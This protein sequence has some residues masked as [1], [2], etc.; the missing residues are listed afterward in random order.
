MR[1]E[2]GVV[3][4]QAGEKE[5]GGVVEGGEHMPGEVA[6]ITNDEVPGV[7]QRKDVGGSG[8]V[9]AVKTGHGEVLEAEGAQGEHALELEQGEGSVLLLVATAGKESGEGI[10]KG[11]GGAVVEEHLRK[12]GEEAVAEA[13]VEALSQDEEGEL[14]EKVHDGAE[15][16][17]PEGLQT[18]RGMAQQAE[19]VLEMGQGKGI[20]GGHGEESLNEE[21]KVE[22]AWGADEKSGAFGQGEEVVGAESL[23]QGQGK[24]A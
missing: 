11:D 22:L 19:V 14:G 12:G 7:G 23:E 2:Q 20:G 8:L 17:L 18:D 15:Q 21:G 24:G 4:A 16:T 1:T 9:V 5:H 13:F 10:G 3:G 6:E